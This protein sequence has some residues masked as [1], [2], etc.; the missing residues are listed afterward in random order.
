[1]E[2]IFEIDAKEKSLSKIGESNV[3]WQFNL[4]DRNMFYLD[5]VDSI[6]EFKT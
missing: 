1:M 5:S 3:S 4:V 6:D 2:A